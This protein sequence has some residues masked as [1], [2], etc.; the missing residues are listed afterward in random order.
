MDQNIQKVAPKKGVIGRFF[1]SFVDVKAWISY[2]EIK[3]NIKSVYGLFRQ[4]FTKRPHVN[5]T[6]ET[7]TEA[8]ARLNLTEQQI[9]QRKKTFLYSA[10][11]YWF[12][13][14]A[15]VAYAVFLIK[16]ALIIPMLFTLILAAFVMALAYREN[17]WYMQ[18]AKRKL[19]CS[20][21]EWLNFMLGKE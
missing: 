20:F 1:K 6:P 10:L 17:L 14:L 15:L 7:F 5:I 13:S 21:A 3:L 19:G 18:M 8:V 4:I 11:L 9:N 16:K 2:D 12:I